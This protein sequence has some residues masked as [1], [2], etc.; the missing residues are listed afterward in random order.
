VA[1]LVLRPLLL[2]FLGLRATSHFFL[3]VFLCEPYFKALCS[4]YGRGVRTG[5]F[6]HWVMGQ[7]NIIL[8]DG[9]EID[10]KCSFTFAARFSDRPTLT[11]GDHTIIRHGCSFTVCRRVSIGKHCLVA[12]GVSLF[13]S[14]GHPLDP[15]AR[16]AGLPPRPEDVRPI[17]I[18]DNVWI[19]QRAIISPGVTIGDNS[20][21]SA[22]SVVV[23]D[24]PPNSVVAGFPAHH[25]ASLEW[26]HPRGSNGDYPGHVNP[27][28]AATAYAERR[29]RAY[30]VA[31]AENRA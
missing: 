3:R 1:R 4:S 5:I 27:S 21:I 30:E 9:V 18:G 26:P 20:I 15:A 28:P 23:S 10:G 6:F 11:I 8:G 22:G 2:A 17:T 29:T 24:V 7:G 19:G 13:E 14:S 25:V 16:L 31:A 12:A